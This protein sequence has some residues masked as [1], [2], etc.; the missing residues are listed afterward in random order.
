MGAVLKI[1]STDR[2]TVADLIQR[3]L[4]EVD[5]IKKIGRTHRYALQMLARMPIGRKVAAELAPSDIID[6]C[7]YRRTAV[8]PA[9]IKQDLC[10]LTGPLGYAKTGWNMDSVST[11]PIKDAKPVLD[12]LQLAGKSRPRDRR[13]TSQE[14][15][16]LIDYFRDQDKRSD[17]PMA[18]MMEFAVYSARRLGEITRLM[19]S[20]VNVQDRTCIIRDMKD[21]RQK[22]GN[23]HEFPLLG[24]AWEIV[25]EQLRS[26]TADRIFPY[27]PKSAGARYTRAKQ[28]L[29]IQNLRF[30]DLRREAASRLFE[31]GFGVQEVMLVTGHKTPAMLLRV[32]TSLK[33]KD[34]HNGPAGKAK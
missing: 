3:Y 2:P 14:F 34:L 6:H 10:Y 29:G 13:P 24:R 21:P 25:E 4:A 8:G 23:D 30:H 1:R 27:N 18:T 9:T 16:L 15:Q 32:Y 31:A 19:R 12:R 26:H 28:M 5:P 22:K 7:R 33:A 11:A 17:I 20:D